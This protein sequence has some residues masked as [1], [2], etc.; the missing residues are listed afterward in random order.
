MPEA[1]R[2]QAMKVSFCISHKLQNLLNRYHLT[3]WIKI[4][5]KKALEKRL[6]INIILQYEQNKDLLGGLIIRIGDRVIDGSIRGKLEKLEK[7][8]GSCL[9]K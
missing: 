7:Y 5:L 3:N 9:K 1:V 4:Q 6:Q 8:F 2:G